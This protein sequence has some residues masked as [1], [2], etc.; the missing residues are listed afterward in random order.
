MLTIKVVFV[1]ETNFERSPSPEDYLE[2]GSP[3]SP[4][5]VSSNPGRHNSL[6]SPIYP[7]ITTQPS[8]R[9]PAKLYIPQNEHIPYGLFTP[10]QAQ[11]SYSKSPFHR[12]DC[13]PDKQGVQGR[14]GSSPS[15][16]FLLLCQPTHLDASVFP[17]KNNQEEVAR[18][19]RHYIQHLATWV[20]A[21]DAPSPRWL[22]ADLVGEP[23]L[24]CAIPISRFRE[25]CH[26]ELAI[27]P[28]CCRLFVLFQGD[29][30][31]MWTQASLQTCIE[32]IPTTVCAFYTLG[33]LTQ[34]TLWTRTYS[35]LPS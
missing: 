19:L 29:T 15:D 3:A 23:S 27:V 4:E 34:S 8:L 30:W 10:E 21:P 2:V 25:L 24:I 14:T 16:R 1:Y 18:L 17:L 6:P 26:N 31:L 5:T 32:N 13:S 11:S 20:C 7:P 35:Q 9:V 28:F 12:D 22:P 33:F